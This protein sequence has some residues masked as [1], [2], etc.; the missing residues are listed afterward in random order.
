LVSAS[1]AS[2]QYED[3][4]LYL[5]KLENKFE[6][7]TLEMLN[8]G[9]L[10]SLTGKHEEAI[11]TYSKVLKKDRNNVIA[12]NNI[13]DELIE[14][15][16]YKV[17][18]QAIEKAIRLKP[19]FDHPYCTFGYLKISQGELEEGKGMINKCLE[20]NSEN[21]YAYKVLG[22]YYLK[23]QDIQQATANF[24]KALTLDSTIDLGPYAED[25]ELSVEAINTSPNNLQSI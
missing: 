19:E 11:E 15:E 24:N 12:L 4:S 1:L 3:T 22:I 10:Q 2:K 25:L 9:C 21:A 8:K 17:A 18:Q 6:L 16:A 14:K 7:S 5:E 23:L 20:L 13:A